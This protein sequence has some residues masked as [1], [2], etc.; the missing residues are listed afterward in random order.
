M[1]RVLPQ[2][3]PCHLSDWRSCKLSS[4]R[5]ANLK[6]QLHGSGGSRSGLYWPRVVNVGIGFRALARIDVSPV[7]PGPSQRPVAVGNHCHF[8]I[9]LTS[10]SIRMDATIGGEAPPFATDVDT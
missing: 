1:A 6:L 9:C 5:S 2:G 3:H 10:W 8:K 7:H 4:V